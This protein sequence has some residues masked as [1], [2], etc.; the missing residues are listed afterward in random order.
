MTVKR[1][2][3]IG[4]GV[5][6]LIIVPGVWAEATAP[7][8][9]KE[10]VTAASTGARE[11]WEVLEASREAKRQEVK[12]NVQ[13]KREETKAKIQNLRD[14]RK[15]KIVE[16]IQTKLGDINQRRTDHFLEVL[17]RLSTILDKIQS[18]TEKAKAAGKNVTSVETALASARTA[19]TTAE[20]AVNAQKG[21]TYQITVNSGTTAKNDVGVTTKQL[22]QDLQ[23]VHDTVKAAGD[24]VQK[25]FTAIKAVV[26]T[27]AGTK[28]ATGSSV[29]Q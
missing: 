17:K 5:I 13:A 8:A 2:L 14:A 6:L 20:T 3:I 27:E 23:T 22:Q 16:K 15:Q 11:R 9:L 4:I 26:G 12:V 10:R 7:G 19:I 24:A 18:R 21:K 29:T 1:S 28:T 25:V